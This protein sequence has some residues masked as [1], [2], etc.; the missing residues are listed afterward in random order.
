M[1]EIFS[2]APPLWNQFTIYC[3]RLAIKSAGL[4]PRQL[5]MQELLPWLCCGVVLEETFLFFL[6]FFLPF[7]PWALLVTTRFCLGVLGEQA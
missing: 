6:S 1:G 7:Y 5:H 4:E 3:D 2:A